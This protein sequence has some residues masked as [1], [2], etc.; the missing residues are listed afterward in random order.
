MCVFKYASLRVNYLYN[1]ISP[2]PVVHLRALA[3]GPWGVPSKELC[4]METY[5]QRMSTDVNGQP[6]RC[7]N[8]LTLQLTTVANPILNRP[9]WD[10]KPTTQLW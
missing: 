4:N 3:C 5:S 2:D 8:M 10:G 7:F 1:K 6:R 9:F